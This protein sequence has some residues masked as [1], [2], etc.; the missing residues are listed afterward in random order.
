MLSAASWQTNLGGGL[1]NWLQLSGG[2]QGS[3]T[4]QPCPFAAA[5]AASRLLATMPVAPEPSR[6]WNV[7]DYDHC[8]PRRVA[9]TC[10]LVACR[11]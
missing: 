8:S 1:P 9:P 10:T 2:I 11:L 5:A 7:S 6:A 4:R 3:A